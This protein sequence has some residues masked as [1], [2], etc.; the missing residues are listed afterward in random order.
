MKKYARKCY[1]RLIM[2]TYRNQGLVSIGNTPPQSVW[3]IVKG[4]TCSFKVYVEDDA[5]N[6]I[7]LSTW[8][9]KMEFKRP[10]VIVDPVIITDDATLILTINP[11]PDEDDLPGEFTVFLAANESGLLHTGDIYDIE[12]SLPNNEIVWTVLQGTIKLVEDVTN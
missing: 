12:L 6:A 8:A 10:N 3:T 5:G 7:D 1:N 11:S 9:I 2:A 4:D